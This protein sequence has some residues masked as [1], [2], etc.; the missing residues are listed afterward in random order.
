MGYGLS[1]SQRHESSHRELVQNLQTGRHQVERVQSDRIVDQGYVDH[2]I[3][4]AAQNIVGNSH[5]RR[6]LPER[7]SL[8]P[9]SPPGVNRRDSRQPS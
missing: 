2:L 8:D 1:P 5:A 3:R 7:V 6:L 4:N 9:L